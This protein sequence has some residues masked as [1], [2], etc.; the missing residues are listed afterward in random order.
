[1]G[2]IF[3]YRKERALELFFAVL[4]NQRTG[5]YTITIQEQGHLSLSAGVRIMISLTG[6]FLVRRCCIGN[7]IAR[8]QGPKQSGCSLLLNLDRR[9]GKKALRTLLL[10][11]LFFT[12]SL[13]ALP[14][15]ARDA[16]LHHDL[17][18]ILLPAEHRIAVADSIT[19]PNESR[20]SIS[21]TLHAGLKPTSPTPGVRI[22]KRA[23]ERGSV[24][25]VSYN[26]V[27]PPGARTFALAYNGL[28]H[29][30]IAPYGKEQ[31]RGYKE[32]PGIISAEG[33][34]LSRASAWYPDFGPG[35]VTFDLTVNLPPDW[36]AVSQG[37]RAVHVQGRNA[38]VVTWRSPE[39]QDEILIVAARFFEYTGPSYSIATM[40]FLR[41]PDEALA[42][43]YLTATK[44]YLEMY[45]SLIGP[46]PYWKFALVEN[47]W[48]TGYGM[49][50]F[51]LLGPTI[52]RLPFIITTSYPHEILHNWWGNGVFVDYETGNWSE[53]LTAYL[54]DHLMQELAGTGSD[55]RL[56]TLQKY[57]DYVF[58]SRD[59]PLSQFHS[60]HSSLSEAIG[61]GKSLMF[62]HMLRLELGDDAF[63]RGLREFYKQ[64][65]FRFAAFTSIRT[66]FEQVSGRDLQTEFEQ[67]VSRAG[68]PMLQLGTVSV[69]ERGDQYFLTIMMKQV[70]PG[71]VYRLH[72]PV[73]V[74]MEGRD[75][76]LQTFID[77][78]TREQEMTVTVPAR[79]LR[80]DVDPEFDLFRRLDREEIPPAISQALGAKKMLVILPSR[81]GKGLLQAYQNFA[82][83]L[84]KSGP[85][86]VEVSLDSAIDALPQDRTVTILGWENLYLEKVVSSTAPYG[87]ELTSQSLR[88]GQTEVRRTDHSIV[89]TARHR[90]TSDIALLFVATDLA[91]ALPGLGR[92]LPH[93]H[94]YSYLA[95]EGQ[96]PEN[97]VKGRWPVIH[98]PMTVFLPD[99]KGAV[100]KGA[101]GKLARREPLATLAPSVSV[102][103]NDHGAPVKEH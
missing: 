54:S 30:R 66:C 11:A 17:K 60:R 47:F 73:A 58:G 65:K 86:D 103:S 71:S 93:Y 91:G 13:Y 50:S 35:L 9:G 43:K 34:V 53:G 84:A 79:P 55:Y 41:S 38:A 95:F 12:I 33:V 2:D 6:R 80:L 40:A 18:V 39:P 61:Y 25:L 94:K 5:D 21:F 96:G 57:T 77:M 70:Q 78:S 100:V 75:Q 29:H 88:I 3:L 74:T 76:A 24:P 68:A 56:N 89:L 27:L 52:I 51:T 69:K 81:A 28:I 44:R 85:D 31:A 59:F 8:V 64:Y 99:E 62:F 92:K 49:P 14:S 90:H 37:E 46:Y 42:N 7:F 87:V 32:T 97:I 10:S 23:K 20:H 101:M 45:N 22:V 19:L 36:D 102:T 15:P 26:I 63:T 16:Y 67:W 98:S 72:I 1:V 4:Y 83:S 82:K 48:E